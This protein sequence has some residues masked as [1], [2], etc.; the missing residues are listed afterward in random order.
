[1]KICT[2]KLMKMSCFN[3]IHFIIIIINKAEIFYNDYSRIVY[4]LLTKLNK[5]CDTCKSNILFYNNILKYTRYNA[6]QNCLP[7]NLCFFCRLL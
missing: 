7:R 5:I 2:K 4:F 1:M 6:S 3:F